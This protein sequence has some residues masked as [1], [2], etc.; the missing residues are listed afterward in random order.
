[1]QSLLQRL[2]TTWQ[3]HSSHLAFLNRPLAGISPKPPKGRASEQSGGQKSNCE[4]IPH[5]GILGSPS[6]LFELCG[7]HWPWRLDKKERRS[8]PMNDVGHLGCGNAKDLQNWTS[9]I[10][11]EVA[12]QHPT[13]EDVCCCLLLPRRRGATTMRDR[14]TI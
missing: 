13:D 4:D 2:F 6:Q 10:A 11:W 3:L 9:V 1:M 5:S 14:G 8:R 12:K 7:N